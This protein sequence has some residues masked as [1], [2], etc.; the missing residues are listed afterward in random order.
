MK[1]QAILAFIILSA[2]IGGGTAWAS[3]EEV[4]PGVWVE[5]FEDGMLLDWEVLGV[6]KAEVTEEKDNSLLDFS[7]SGQL[8][9]ADMRFKDVVAEVTIT[10]GSGGIRFG[11][12]YQAMLSASSLDISEKRKQLAALKRSY[13]I[14]RSYRLKVVCAGSF[15]RVYVN[16]R[17]EFEKSDATPTKGPIAL[18]TGP[19]G[20][21]VDDVRIAT[22][23]SPQDGAMAIPLEDD[24][25]LVFS[26]AADAKV[27][28]KTVNRSARSVTV[29]AAVRRFKGVYVGDLGGD[30]EVKANGRTIV[31]YG[32]QFLYSVEPL[33]GKPVRLAQAALKA[34]SARAVE[35]NLGKVPPGTYLLDIS[36][37]W[38]GKEHESGRFLFAAFDDIAP[39]EYQP[40]LIPIGPYTH[41]M[42]KA[43]KK[44]NPLWWYTYLHAAALTLKAH[45]LNAVVACGMYERDT[46]EIYNRYG[47]AVVQR[48]GSHL[49]HPGVISTLA[50]DEPHTS[51]MEYYREQYANLERITDKPVMTC[52]VG[53]GIGMGGKYFF[54]KETNP[55][56][57]IFRWYGIKK[58]FYGIRHHLIYKGVLP[59]ADVLRIS[60]ASFDTPYWTILPTNGGTEHEAYFQ[61]PSPAQHRGLMHLSMAYGARGVLLYSLQAA[62]GVGLVDTVTLKP[63]GG[64][65]AAIGEVAGHV[66]KHAKLLQSLK[67]GKFDVRCESPDI[68]PVPLHDGGDG[69]YV[70]A[71]NRNTKETVS[72]RLFWPRKLGRA[73]VH[74]I[75]A[76]AAAST[77]TDERYVSLALELAPGEGR[78]LAVS[79]GGQ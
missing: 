49:D 63:N 60:D 47:V 64:N 20:V 34:K 70:Y 57:R 7:G 6:A 12:K 33:P 67:V 55:R 11:G 65:L 32:T 43:A 77:E 66:K 52:C 37:S 59:L 51:E 24:Q 44:E 78:L 75:F 2:I 71:I 23:L 4:E 54:W 8:A 17:K 19:Q 26:S 16:G 79:E 18:V 40:P 27:R 73:K 36:F 56:I 25:A 35:L 68:E 72:C 50:G 10:G 62:F 9:L 53:E 58:H 5:D 28:L 46:I 15:I 45:N 22:K 1:Y 48:G 69:R 13:K 74:D 61:Y 39:V 21:L 30:E 31:M 76:G 3:L 29:Q 14:G 42:P 41:K 38:A